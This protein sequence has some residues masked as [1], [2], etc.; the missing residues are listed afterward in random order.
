MTATD[1]LRRMLDERGV[2]YETYIEQP[3]G[4]EHVKWNFN[5]HGSADFNLEFGEP[6]LTM[7]GVISGPEQAIA[8]T[9][10]RG[11]LTAE[12]VRGV[13][14]LHLPHREY[15]SIEQT[16]GWQAIADELNATLGSC[17]CSNNCTNSERTGTCHDKGTFN[18]WGY[19][20]C[21]NCSIVIPL[22]AVKDAPSI[23]RTLPPKY[24]P[25]CGAKVVDPTTNDVDV[26]VDA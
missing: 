21:S 19:F 15:Y 4:F 7:Y 12:Q 9:L 25:N 24:C 14:L 18:S 8:A 20:T 11:M 6:W 16:D 10:G 3:T 2:E 17:N 5:E 13:L 26:E 22:D 1:E 23:G